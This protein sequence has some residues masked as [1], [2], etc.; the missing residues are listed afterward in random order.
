MLGVGNLGEGKGLVHADGRKSVYDSCFISRMGVQVSS[1]R[2][3]GFERREISIKVLLKY[4]IIY[5]T[6][7]KYIYKKNSGYK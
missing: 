5:Y 3:K 1:I 6:K 4:K 7:K 2:K